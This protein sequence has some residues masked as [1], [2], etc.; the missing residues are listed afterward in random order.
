VDWL[1]SLYLIVGGSAFVLLIVSALSGFG[2]DTDVSH[3]VHFDHGADLG[4]GHSDFS[5]G[6][7][8]LSIRVLMGALV[9]FGAFGLIG[10]GLPIPMPATLLVAVA[11]FFVMAFVVKKYILTPMYRQQSNSTASDKDYIGRTGKIIIEVR[12]GRNGLV[13]FAGRGMELVTGTAI[14]SGGTALPAGTAVIIVDVTPAG[15]IVEPN[16]LAS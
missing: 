3:E 6:P 8:W 1:T 13:R 2:H 14:S 7:S 9:G 12:E 10:T 4:A 15:L 5:D 11:G 16:P